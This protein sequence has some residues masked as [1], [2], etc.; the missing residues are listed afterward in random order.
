MPSRAD[1]ADDVVLDAAAGHRALD[2]AVVAHGEHRARRPR[3]AAP[4]LDDGDEQHA[5]A[6]VE[7]FGAA[8]Q[9]FEIDAVHGHAPGKRAA[10]S[11]RRST[12]ASSA[13]TGY[14]ST[15][16]DE[17]ERDVPNPRAA[18]GP[19]PGPAPATGAPDR[20][21]GDRIGKAREEIVRELLRRAVDEPRADLR[22]LAADLRVHRVGQRRRRAVL[23]RGERD[24]RLALGEAGRPALP[25]ERQRVAVRRVDVGEL[26]AAREFR[27][28]GPDARRQR[29]PVRVLA[30]RARSTRSRECRP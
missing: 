25:V 7:P 22:D 10:S 28:H 24:L 30:V 5:P 12:I 16:R 15:S 14:A 29:D 9:D 26:H 2:E 6:G 23:G 8:L 1:A 11:P 3:R 20:L 19:P 4:G 17:R 21:R 13:R 18:A 27:R